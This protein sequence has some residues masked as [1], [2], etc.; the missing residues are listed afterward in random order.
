MG[1]RVLR[2]LHCVLKNNSVYIA[3]FNFR[4]ITLCSIP[5]SRPALNY[6][7]FI[8]NLRLVVMKELFMSKLLKRNL[9]LSLVDNLVMAII[10]QYFE[11]IS[12]SA[13]LFA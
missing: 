8:M 6:L 9:I 5:K 2:K 1:E 13:E 3:D 4:T 10:L 12:E 7:R 11:N